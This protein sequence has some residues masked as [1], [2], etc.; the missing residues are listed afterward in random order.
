MFLLLLLLHR[1]MFIIPA[2]HPPKK[3]LAKLLFCFIKN[4]HENSAKPVSFFFSQW[5]NFR[6]MG[7]FS[8]SGEICPRF[9]T[10]IPV[11]SWIY[12]WKS[13]EIW[14]F[15]SD[16]SEALCYEQFML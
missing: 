1:L 6:E 14:L 12:L 15:F 10:K 4:V 5:E 11:K 3:I 16:L 7:F 8:Y 13:N 2:P 9:F